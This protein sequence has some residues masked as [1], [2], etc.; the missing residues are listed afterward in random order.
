MF[1]SWVL[2]SWTLS[3]ISF[4]NILG[5]RTSCVF[6]TVG[7]GTAKLEKK[8]G[9][10]LVRHLFEIPRVAFPFFYYYGPT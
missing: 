6:G 10:C 9:V 8:G 7:D 4:G 1:K 5:V 2:N 3:S